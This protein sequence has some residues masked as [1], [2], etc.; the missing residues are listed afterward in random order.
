M[1][2]G[3]ARGSENFSLRSACRQAG[4][5]EEDA[6]RDARLVLRLLSSPGAALSGEGSLLREKARGPCCEASVS[7]AGTPPT[8]VTVECG[9]AH[10]AD[11]CSGS[12]TPMAAREHA[13]VTQLV[14]HVL[15]RKV[16]LLV[17]TVQFNQAALA[18]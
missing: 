13:F 6:L 10:V 2:A 14:M 12:A 17:N 4:S 9:A 11:M 1:T 18:N 3:A 8:T 7:A 16:C 15:T 5:G